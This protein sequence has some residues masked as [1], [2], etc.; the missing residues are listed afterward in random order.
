MTTNIPSRFHSE[1][2]YSISLFQNSYGDS[3]FEK[4]CRNEEQ[5]LQESGVFA[6]HVRNDFS[7]V[8]GTLFDHLRISFSAPT[9]LIIPEVGR[10]DKQGKGAPHLGTA[11]HPSLVAGLVSYFQ[12]TYP[13]LSLCLGALNE[14]L[15]QHCVS[16]YSAVCPGCVFSVIPEKVSS[17]LFLI[18]VPVVH[19]VQESVVL[20]E[21][22]SELLSRAAHFV[23]VVDCV[24]G[25]ANGK[26]GFWN[27]V[28]GGQRWS[29]IVDYFSQFRGSDSLLSFHATTVEH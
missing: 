16:L 2:P 12:E 11:V 14:V 19:F 25:D 6:E 8:V 1:V 17:D 18:A 7:S 29:E 13:D 3:W 21:D 9:I 10:G 27:R 15:L 26:P 4:I 20:C 5:S 22:F 24:I 23:V 28:V